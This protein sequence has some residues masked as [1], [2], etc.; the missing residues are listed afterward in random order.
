MA[1]V[2]RS[3]ARFDYAGVAQVLFGEPSGKHAL[4]AAYEQLRLLGEVATRLRAERVRRGG[5]IFDLPE[6][7]VILAPMIRGS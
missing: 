6:A 2:I 7:K 4:Q 3:R 1:A 5:L